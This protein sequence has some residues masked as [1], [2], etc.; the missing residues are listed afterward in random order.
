MT[1]IAASY[2]YL[3]RQSLTINHPAI[4]ILHILDQLKDSF[5]AQKEAM[6]DSKIQIQQNQMIFSRNKE[7]TFLMI[8][9]EI[10]WAILIIL[11]FN[12]DTPI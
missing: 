11:C 6:T 2:K 7:Y 5:L 8:Q 4:K 9:M 10:L 12:M 3:H 1:Q